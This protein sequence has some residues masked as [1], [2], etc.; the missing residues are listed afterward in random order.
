MV[1]HLSHEQQLQQQR[2]PPLVAAH[3]QRYLPIER[4]WGDVVDNAAAAGSWGLVG[5]L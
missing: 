4:C 3:R 5:T 1:G 2:A